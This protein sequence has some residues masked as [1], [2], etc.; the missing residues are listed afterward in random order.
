M[1]S[2]HGGQRPSSSGQGPSL[3]PRR[4]S[5]SVNNHPIPGT[6]TLSLQ[7][8]KFHL[9]MVEEHCRIRKKCRKV[10]LNL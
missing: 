6:Q 10:I 7:V 1:P 9:T 8:H 2:I 5:S 4:P 3:S